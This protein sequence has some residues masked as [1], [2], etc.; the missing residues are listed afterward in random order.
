[1]KEVNSLLLSFNSLPKL[2]L[3]FKET[4]MGLS[5]ELQGLVISASGK[6]DPD[7]NAKRKL[8][9]AGNDLKKLIHKE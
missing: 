2:F 5:H 8:P 9:V 1:M 7:H 4:G 3:F 6:P